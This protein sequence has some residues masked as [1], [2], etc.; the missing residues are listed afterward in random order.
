MED[1]IYLECSFSDKD[2]VKSLGARYESILRKWYISA[3]EDLTLFQRWLP[4]SIVSK[5]Q[6]K[7]DNTS[8]LTIRQIISTVQEKIKEA[9]S[10]EI[11]LIGQIIKVK[12]TENGL[13]LT[14]LD[15]EAKN[16]TGKDYKLDVNIWAENFNMIKLKFSQ[17]VGQDLAENM[18]IR[19]KVKLDYNAYGLRGIATDIDPTMTLGEVAAQQ[20]AI[21]QKLIKE[22]IYYS[23]SE[24]Q[25]PV[26][27]CRVIVIHPDNSSGFH[28]F[29]HTAERLEQLGLCQFIYKKAKFEGD[30]TESSILSVIAEAIEISKTTPIDALVIIRGG[31]AREGLY[32]LIKE[33]IIRAICTFPLPV[34]IGVGHTDDKLLLD[35]IACCSVGTPSKTIEYIFSLISKN[36]KNASTNFY[37]IISTAQ[38]KLKNH[39]KNLAISVAF[40]NG[41]S[42]STLYSQITMIKKYF[43]EIESFSKRRVLKFSQNTISIAGLISNLSTRKLVGYESNLKQNYNQVITLSSNIVKQYK[44]DVNFNMEE[45]LCDSLTITNKFSENINEKFQDVSTIAGQYRKRMLDKLNASFSVIDALSPEKTLERGYCLALNETGVIRLKETAYSLK[46]FTLRFSDGECKVNIIN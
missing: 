37:N 30:N 36:A 34:I 32:S 33:S 16:N 40:I 11:W 39:Q 6:V 4:K 27:F 7:K 29:R 5:V 13:F 43:N 17:V 22:G 18:K 15:D 2:R 10:Q 26:D 20:A 44:M 8:Y 25:K 21:K 38:Q 3:S 23:N 35:E 45:I 12:E 9:Y 28:D 19:L 42:Q 14:L 41:K 1:R 24:K 31:G 46:K